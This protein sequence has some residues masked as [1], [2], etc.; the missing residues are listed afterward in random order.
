MKSTVLSTQVLFYKESTHFVDV[1]VYKTRAAMRG[2][3]RKKGDHDSSNTDAACWQ[4][5]GLRKDNCIA[6][7]YFARTHL[8]LETIAHECTHAAYHRAELIG[9]K[10]DDHRF[11]EYVASD[12]GK[13]TDTVI[14]WLDVNRVPVKLA[15]VP[16][17]R[18]TT[19]GK[20][21]QEKK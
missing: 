4:P 21:N 12:A 13:L 1:L 18:V 14:A 2:A 7:L 11:Q 10:L 17:R 19:V 20:P 6:M 3:L 16:S 9:L 5:N 15:C 8:T